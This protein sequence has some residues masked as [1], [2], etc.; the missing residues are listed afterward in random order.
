[1]TSCLL[2]SPSVSVV[3]CADTGRKE[4]IRS[5]KRIILFIEDNFRKIRSNFDAGYQLFVYSLIALQFETLWPWFFSG[6]WGARP[7][8]EAGLEPLRRDLRGSDSALEARSDDGERG[9]RLRS[10]DRVD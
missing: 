9:L 5:D 3:R 10:R 1:M 7:G 6:T 8:E 4:E 2:Q